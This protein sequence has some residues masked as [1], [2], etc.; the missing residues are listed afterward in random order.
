M[1]LAALN[2]QGGSYKH[3]VDKEFSDYCATV[4]KTAYQAVFENYQS[5]TDKPV[6]FNTCP[7]P[8]VTQDL[9]NF[10]LEDKAG[11]LPPYVSGSE[12]WKVTI[13]FS[14]N[15]TVLGGYD[16]YASLRNND[17]MMWG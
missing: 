5:H 6:A 11:L 14:R 17:T 4:Y 1:K 10:H 2:H 3:M 12:K 16:L 8:A 13:R 7:Y 9:R 15:G